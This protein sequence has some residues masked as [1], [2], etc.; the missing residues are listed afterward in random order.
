[1]STAS[2]I[3]PPFFEMNVERYR[4]FGAALEKGKKSEAEGRHAGPQNAK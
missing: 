2:F 1:V 3:T 4:P